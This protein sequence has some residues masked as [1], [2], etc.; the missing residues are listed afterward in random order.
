MFACGSKKKNDN[1]DKI[2]NEIRSLS[3]MHLGIKL[4]EFKLEFNENNGEW[5]STI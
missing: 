4:N 5:K 2:L 3:G 1:P